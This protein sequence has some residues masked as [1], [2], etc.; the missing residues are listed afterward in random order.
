MKT[1][2]LLCS[3]F[4]LIALTAGTAFAATTSV[5][6]NASRGDK[7]SMAYRLSISQ[8]YASWISNGVLELSPIAEMG[9]HA[10]VPDDSGED[11]IWGA[12]VAPG[13][14]FTLLTDKGIRPYLEGSFGGAFSTEREIDTRDLGSHALFRTRGTVG[15]SFGDDFRHRIQGDYVHYSNFGIAN[16]NDGYNTYGVS[17]GYS[18]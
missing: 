12:F 14:R 10:W 8:L 2:Q 16:H 18:F 15:L 5:G 4:L 6:L 17:Y 9:A 7:D 1:N 3:V 13:I 11:T